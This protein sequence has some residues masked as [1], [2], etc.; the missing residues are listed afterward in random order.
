[1]SKIAS[2][3]Y[4]PRAR[5]YSPLFCFG[6][7]LRRGLAL[8]RVLLPQGIT[9]GG[10]AGSFLIPGLGVFLRGPRIYGKAAVAG[11][12]ML[13]LFFIVWLG[14]PFGSCMFGLMLSLHATGFV[15][16]CGPHFVSRPFSHRLLFTLAALVSIGLGLYLPIRHTVQNHWLLPLRNGGQVIIV[17][18]QR[19]VP[20]KRGDWAAFNT[21]DG[22][23]FGRITGLGGDRI[24]SSTVP[25][26]RWLL[27]TQFSRQYYSHGLFPAHLG[28]GGVMEQAIIVSPKEFIGIPFKHWFWRKQI[29]Q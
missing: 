16:Y 10:L 8:D 21:K 20:L 12:V 11:W 7:H 25:E 27:R 28:S 13:F 9:A 24:D 22:V 18:V 5:W 29:L 15:Y 19:A 3:Y 23:L 2:P 1:M 14:Y 17:S 4:P 6:N 26:N